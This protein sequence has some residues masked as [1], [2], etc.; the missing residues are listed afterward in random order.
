MKIK[1]KHLVF[2]FFMYFLA[3]IALV[4]VPGGW[5]ADTDHC[6][7]CHG[8]AGMVGEALY[9]DGD[10]FA[11][12]R[13]GDMGCVACHE[14]AGYEHPDDGMALAAVNCNDC[15]FDVEKEYN[16]G[17]HAGLASCNDCHEPHS[18]RGPTEVSGYDMNLM[19][20]GCHSVSRMV[21]SHN[22]WLPQAG[23][24]IEAVPC[25]TCHTDSEEVVITW[26]L[27]KQKQ[28]YGD[29]VLMSN[30]ELQEVAGERSIT[31]LVDRDGDGHVSLAELRAFNTAREFRGLHLVGM[32]TPE[33]V[34]H[35]F[36]VLDN[37]WDCTFCHASGPEA[38]QVSYLAF[39]R[40]DGSFKRLDVER[41]AALD[42]LYGTPNF[43]MV[44]ATRNKT[45]DILGAMII[46]GGL[47]L[48]VGHGTMRFFT[49]KNRQGGH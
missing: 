31:E 33:Q 8:D 15:H 38:M 44:G 4:A 32:M 28:A 5:A 18:V 37:R 45:M 40:G 42:A 49:R 36:Q 1:A 39:P 10:K 6:L 11:A 29:F 7:M 46:A 21:D 30:E 24:H 27:V 2:L 9:V 22:R 13:H 48:P 12:T 26:Y 34:S 19:C 17:I 16:A 23:L 35:N 14:D 20:I 43:Y 47:V 3:F 41:G 25:I